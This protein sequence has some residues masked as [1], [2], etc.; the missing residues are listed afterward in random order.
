MVLALSMVSYT[1]V[2][3]TRRYYGQTSLPSDSYDDRY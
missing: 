2:R 3:G 1:V